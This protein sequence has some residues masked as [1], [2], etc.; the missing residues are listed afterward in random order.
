MSSYIYLSLQI[1]PPDDSQS[2]QL[3]EAVLYRLAG[4][5]IPTRHMCILLQSLYYTIISAYLQKSLTFLHWKSRRNKG[6]KR[7]LPGLF[8]FGKCRLDATVVASWHGLHR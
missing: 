4:M 3:M 7:R 8:T 5:H 6:N 1:N 2:A